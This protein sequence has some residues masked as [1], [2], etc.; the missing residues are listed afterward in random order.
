M[1]ETNLSSLFS[2]WLF[3]YMYHILSYNIKAIYM[4]TVLTAVNPIKI[5]LI[6]SIQ[7]FFNESIFSIYFHRQTNTPHV[8]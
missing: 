3:N 7:I 8:D 5:V 2:H 1:M 4:Y 6:K